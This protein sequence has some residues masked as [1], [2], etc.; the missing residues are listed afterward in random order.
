[1][2]QSQNKV[3]RLPGW[4]AINARYIYPVNR[5]DRYRP[6]VVEQEGV[7]LFETLMKLSLLLTKLR[8]K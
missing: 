4:S 5:K 7:I 6:K 8:W 3:K 1:M 2:A